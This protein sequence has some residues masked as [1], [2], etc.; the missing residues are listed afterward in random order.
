MEWSIF[1]NSNGEGCRQK[2]PVFIS[3]RRTGSM[4]ETSLRCMRRVI[5]NLTE[6]NGKV[7]NYKLLVC[8]RYALFKSRNPHKSPGYGMRANGSEQVM[9][10]MPPLYRGW[11]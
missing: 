9:I 2:E 8:T 7:T 4:M 10:S 3:A 11:G 5:Q 1:Y 6:K